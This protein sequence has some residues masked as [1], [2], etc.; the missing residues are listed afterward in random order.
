MLLSINLFI[1]THL[2][3][4]SN[5]LTLLSSFFASCFI[6]LRGE[7]LSPLRIPLVKYQ[8]PLEKLRRRREWIRTFKVCAK[9]LLPIHYFINKNMIY[10]STSFSFY[11]N[12]RCFTLQVGSSA[13]QETVAVQA[14]SRGMPTWGWT[15]VSTRY[16][17][18]KLHNIEYEPNRLWQRACVPSLSVSEN[19]VVISIP[20]WRRDQQ[21]WGGWGGGSSCFDSS[22]GAALST[23][24]ARST[25]WLPTQPPAGGFLTKTEGGKKKE[26]NL[27]SLEDTHV[28][29]KKFGPN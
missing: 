6:F 11:K 26:I 21:W 25:S 2:H 8:F 3:F 18:E 5:L 13:H 27:Q 12:K 24:G 14:I 7:K 4:A 19:I 15:W 22:G 23:G 9:Y 10:F 17:Q 28:G 16:G 20:G 1:Q 29:S